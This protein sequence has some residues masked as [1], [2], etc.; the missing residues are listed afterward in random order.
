M[1]KIIL[2]FTRSSLCLVRF[3][4]DGRD[5]PSRAVDGEADSPLMDDACIP[6]D[7]D[8]TLSVIRS[9]KTS[10]SFCNELIRHTR[11]GLKISGVCSLETVMR[12]REHKNDDDK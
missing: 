10:N 7:I 12:E 4:S 8:M 2:A 11:S 1:L 3:S 5:G 6:V 9:I